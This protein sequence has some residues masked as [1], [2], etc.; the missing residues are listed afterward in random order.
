M[1]L[2]YA[3]PH[4]VYTDGWVVNEVADI[5]GNFRIAREHVRYGTSKQVNAAGQSEDQERPV[6][7]VWPERRVQDVLEGDEA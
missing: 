5:V 7:G 6:E 1:L 4:D 3:Q 2:T